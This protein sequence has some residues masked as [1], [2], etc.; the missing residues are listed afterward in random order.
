MTKEMKKTDTDVSK[1]SKDQAPENKASENKTQ[2]QTMYPAT[3]IHETKEGATLYIDLPGVS[4]DAL[5]IDV[6]QNVLTVKG[7][8]N[9]ATPDDLTPTY[10]DVRAGAFKRQFTLSAELDSN[11]VDAQLKDGVLKLVIPRS[12]K[13]KP[14]KIEVKAA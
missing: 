13:H 9:L 2:V 3:D 11:K 7:D 12:E 5:D 4:R 8:I 6:D 10:M 14:R 1:V